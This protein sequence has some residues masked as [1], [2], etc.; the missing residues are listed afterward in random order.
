MKYTDLKSVMIQVEHIMIDKDLRQK[1]ISNATGWSR[2]T[3]SNL[4]ACRRDTVNIDTLARLCDAIDCDLYIDVRPRDN[5]WSRLLDYTRSLYRPVALYMGVVCHYIVV[6]GSLVYI[7]CMDVIEPL[8]CG[9]I[10]ADVGKLPRVVLIV[11][12]IMAIWRLCGLC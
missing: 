4:L 7:G 12:T 8:E 6:M 1:D 10:W 5:D 2:Q 11:Y 3:V 9:K